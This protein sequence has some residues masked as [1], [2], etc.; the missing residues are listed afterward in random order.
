MGGDQLTK[1][2]SHDRWEKLSKIWEEKGGLELN[3]RGDRRFFIE[4]VVETDEPDLCGCC[5]LYADLVGPDMP[6]P[7]EA[8]DAFIELWEKRR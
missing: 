8:V 5:M 4:T 6:T 1:D 7:E 2:Q 3:N